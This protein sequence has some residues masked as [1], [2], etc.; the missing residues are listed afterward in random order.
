VS[1]DSADPLVIYLSCVP[2]LRLPLSFSF[3]FEFFAFALFGV[4]ICCACVFQ[5][6]IGTVFFFAPKFPTSLK[7]ILVATHSW[8]HAW[9][10]REPEFPPAPIRTSPRRAKVRK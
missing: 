1:P 10:L 5:D 9:S 7:G 6:L 3:A 4:F 8:H 2:V